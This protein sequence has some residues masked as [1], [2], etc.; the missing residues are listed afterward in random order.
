PPDA[1]PPPYAPATT[2]TTSR[3][4]STPFT[5]PGQQALL[6]HCADHGAAMTSTDRKVAARELLDF[7][8]EAGVD[9]LL[10]ET[11]TDR[12]A[13]DQASVAPAAHAEVAGP[14]AEASAAATARSVPARER[15]LA[16]RAAA[17]VPTSPDAA[18]MAARAAAKSA[19]SLVELRAMLERFEGC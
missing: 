13:S 7:Y 19:A 14:R 10:E 3:G 8:R 1:A 16:S 11:P 4:W 9:A 18:V 6:R 12:L 17:A 2:V 5:P 15:E